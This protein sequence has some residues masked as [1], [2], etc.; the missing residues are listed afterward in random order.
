MFSWMLQIFKAF[1]QWLA[2]LALGIIYWLWDT[3]VNLI[4]E[5]TKWGMDHLP[6]GVR[7]FLNSSVAQ[8]APMWDFFDLIDW[9]V[10]VQG[11]LGICITTVVFVAGIRFVRYVL[12]VS[13]AGISGGT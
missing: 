12:G 1:F 10:P 2:D 9:Y 13:F 6:E 7:D 8:L 4:M 3:G 5:F 11:V